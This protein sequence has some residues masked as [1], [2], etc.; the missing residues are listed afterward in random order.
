MKLMNF[1]IK[2]S[3]FVLLIGFFHLN[4]QLLAE[5]KKNC[6]K[7]FPSIGTKFIVL[8][9]NQFKIRITDSKRL[10]D[11]LN[12]ESL[13][14]H[15]ALLKLDVVESYQKFIRN[16]ISATPTEYG[17]TKFTEKFD[18]SWNTMKK[19][20]AS[21]R[22]LGTCIEKDRILFSGE[23]TKNSITKVSKII[24]LEDLYDE[25][26]SLSIEDPEF[27]IEDYP[28][29]LS[30]EDPIFIKEFLENWKKNRSF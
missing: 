13:A 26:L 21:M 9:E 2:I 30:T 1:L 6:P 24:E 10:Q 14:E 25:L 12:D 5:N 19:S 18:N 27:K 20:I 22:N 8:D 23:W 15:I 16:E 4:N 17:G 7:D 11:A 28:F 29:L 3:R